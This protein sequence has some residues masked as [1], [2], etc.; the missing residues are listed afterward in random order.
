MERKH[1]LLLIIALIAGGGVEVAINQATVPQTN[2]PV[3]STSTTPIVNPLP[4]PKATNCDPSLWLFVYHPD[5]LPTKDDC[6][7]V[8]GIVKWDKV[9]PDGDYH[10]RLQLDDPNSAPV[11]A[12]N[13]GGYLVVEPICQTKNIPQS[14]AVGPCASYNGPLFPLPIVGRHYSV[15]GFYTEDLQH[16]WME[17]HAVSH[18]D[19][20]P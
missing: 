18:L 15:S 6:R 7:N 11:N 8:M 9:E 16:S 2:T 1:Y 13:I 14:D 4:S 12:K 3:L 19:L 10:I 17:I 5:R 20:V